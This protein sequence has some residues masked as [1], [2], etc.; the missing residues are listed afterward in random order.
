M[1]DSKLSALT[2][3]AVEMADTDEVYVNDGG[4]SK[5]QAYSVLKAPFFR[6]DGTVD[7]TGE[8]RTDVGTFD[9]D[10]ANGASAVAY[11]YDTQN[12]YSTSGAKLASW[13]NNA[14][15]KAYINKDGVISSIASAGRE[16]HIGSDGSN[17]FVNNPVTALSVAGISRVILS[18]YSPTATAALNETRGLAFEMNASAANIRVGRDVYPSGTFSIYHADY[19]SDV[20]PRATA[21]IGAAAYASAATNL[22]G[23]NLTIAAGA[24]ASGSA[25][26]ADGGNITL[27]GGQGYGT[28]DH[29]NVI[30]GATRGDLVFS[31]D[32]TV[33]GLSTGVVGKVA[34]VTDASGPTMGATVA[35]GGAAAALVWYNGTN[36]TVIGV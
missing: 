24:G 4:V 25:G 5:K 14:T 31:N 19:T 7:M 1:A 2:A 34:R 8:L 11:S 32:Y 26:D 9:S 15:E 35:G 29:G 16:I 27:D 18:S 6:V 36:W 17:S 3:L 28:G 23:G 30:I 20:A 21:I 13:K 22:D 12:T 33:A 10:V